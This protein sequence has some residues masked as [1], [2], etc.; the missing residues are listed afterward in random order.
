MRKL[1]VFIGC[2]CTF[3][4][5]LIFAWILS[6]THF[7]SARP[8]GTFDSYDAISV[9]ITILGIIL[10]AVGLGLAAAAFFGYQALE[11]IV[12]RRADELVNQRL[13]RLEAEESPGDEAKPFT[14]PTPPT[15]G[16]SEETKKL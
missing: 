7:H 1:A 2:I 3:A 16:V 9:Q 10:G 12:L 15:E 14:E 6:T 8:S 4:N 11:G 13:K 5:V